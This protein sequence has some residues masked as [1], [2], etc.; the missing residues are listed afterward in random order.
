MSE[1]ENT[2]YTRLM[3]E[4]SAQTQIHTEILVQTTHCDN[5]LWCVARHLWQLL[6]QARRVAQLSIAAAMRQSDERE[7]RHE[8]QAL[9]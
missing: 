9:R 5:S 6:L 3:H 4:G 7:K 2:T 1:Q 8:I